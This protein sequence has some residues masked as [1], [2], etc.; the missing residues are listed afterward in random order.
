M[1]AMRAGSD[2]SKRGDR[3]RGEGVYELNKLA[4]AVNSADMDLEKLW[5]VAEY[6]EA[7]NAEQLA[8]LAKVST[9][10]TLC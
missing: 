3:R 5:A 8:Q 4:A 7:E 2:A 9:L 1:K 10:F 6:A